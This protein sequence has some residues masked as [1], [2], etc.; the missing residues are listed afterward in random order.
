MR[1]DLSPFCILLHFPFLHFPS[2]RHPFYARKIV[3]DGEISVAIAAR[4]RFHKIV[5]RVSHYRS[6]TA[7][8][9]RSMMPATLG[10]NVHNQGNL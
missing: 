7:S 6:K 3:Y 1:P 2:L 5:H 10:G 8:G 9:T 4:D